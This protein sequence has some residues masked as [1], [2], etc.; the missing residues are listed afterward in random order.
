MRWEGGQVEKGERSR[1]RSRA[2]RLKHR[3]NNPKRTPITYFL[4][5]MSNKNLY[6]EISKHIR[7]FNE[8]IKDDSEIQVQVKEKFGTKAIDCLAIIDYLPKKCTDKNCKVCNS[9][10]K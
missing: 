8:M 7:K 3:L 9:K 2:E 10:I 4:E 1:H 5:T 6:Y